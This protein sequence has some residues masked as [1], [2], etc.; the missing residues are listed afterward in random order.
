MEL[1]ARRA[2]CGQGV[3]CG[4]RP[5]ERGSPS[6]ARAGAGVVLATARPMGSGSPLGP[7]PKQ[8][9]ITR[10]GAVADVPSSFLNGASQ[11]EG[12]A[13]GREEACGG[14]PPT[15]PWLA[16][17]T[18]WEANEEVALKTG[19]MPALLTPSWKVLLL[20]DGSVT[21]HLQLLTDIKVEVGLVDET[22]VGTTFGTPAGTE[23]I[24]GPLLQRQVYLRRAGGESLAY[25]A[26]W[27]SEADM[28]EYMRDNDKPIWQNLAARRAELYREVQRVY[29]GHNEELEREFGHKGPFWGRHYTF[30]HDGRPLTLI[31]EVFSPRLEKWL[32][33]SHPEGFESLW[34]SE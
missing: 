7:G 28:A 9:R 8:Q 22:A 10:L 20:S 16:L 13:Y 4:R 30:W 19:T 21:R 1:A 34:S 31:Y 12:L 18:L 23:R 27:W 29:L 6:S 26:S 3:G 33:T 11:D 14:L 5:A 32:G 25:A 2:L 15:H 17:E 24:E